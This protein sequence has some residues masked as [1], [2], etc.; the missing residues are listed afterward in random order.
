MRMVQID[1]DY[2]GS[3]RC[4]A[5]HVPSSVQLHT[6]APVDNQGRGESFSPTDLLATSLGSCMLTIMAIVAGKRDLDF[7]GATANV[8]KHMVA[9]PA[10]RIGRLEV[11]L[12]IPGTF[13]DRQRE[14][15]EAAAK[16]CP[17]AN[18]IGDAMDVDLSI[19]W[20]A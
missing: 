11:T 4:E 17:V 6:D 3:L 8:A 7:T 15:L 9:D 12:R 19:V 2:Q 14:V 20:G 16:T 10:R 5:R 18:S 1:I 13:D